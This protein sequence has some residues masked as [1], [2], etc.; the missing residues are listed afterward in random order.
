MDL[1][2]LICHDKKRS[3]FLSRLKMNLMLSAIRSS[4]NVD[5]KYEYSSGNYFILQISPDHVA[6][7]IIDD[8]ESIS[9]GEK[10]NN[11]L[12]K[13]NA[14]YVVFID[15]DDLISS[16]Y[17]IQL[18][19]AIEKDV[20]CCG[21]IGK[22]F[23]NG[24][25]KSNFVHSIKYKS[26]YEEEGVLVRPPNHLNMIRSEIAKKF[27]FSDKNYGEDTEWA[28]KIAEADVLKTEYEV[29]EPIYYYEKL[30]YEP[31]LEASPLPSS[32]LGSR[33]N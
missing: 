31:I 21:L 7:V 8:T 2:I 4:I 25:F 16:D 9:I 3:V 6:E 1:S 20:D 22:Y 10:R 29:K 32:G 18:S 11:L 23:E 26:Y 12:Q 13:A 14:K 24:I 17:F 19:N 30:T 28:M 33:F 15:D 5:S 27:S